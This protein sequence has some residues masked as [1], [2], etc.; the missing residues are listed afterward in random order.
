[1]LLWSCAPA[2]SPLRPSLPSIELLWAAV[3]GTS[4]EHMWHIRNQPLIARIFRLPFFVT[5]L[6][7]ATSLGKWIVTQKHHER[8]SSSDMASWEIHYSWRFLMGDVPLSWLILKAWQ[9]P[10]FCLYSSRHKNAARIA[11]WFYI[12]CLNIHC[13]LPWFTIYIHLAS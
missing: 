9:H 1:M 12:T 4:S 6:Q 2:T 7:D 8:C 3:S 10:T 11:C 5:W 13:A